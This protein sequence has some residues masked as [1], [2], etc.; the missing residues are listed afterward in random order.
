MDEVD[1]L[2]SDAQQILRH[3]MEKDA[4]NARFFLI[5]NDNNAIIPALQSR[6]ARFRFSPLSDN[7]IVMRLQ[8][9]CEAE[10]IKYHKSSEVLQ[11]I[12][13]LSCGDMRTAYSITESLCNTNQKEEQKDDVFLTSE[14]V[15]NLT[16][17]PSPEEV[18]LIF[19]ILLNEPL[20]V[21]FLQLSQILEQKQYAL[22]DIVTQLHETIVFKARFPP[23][24]FGFLM[25]EFGKL[26]LQIH[27]STNHKLQLGCLIGIFAKASETISKKES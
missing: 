7:Q 13:H 19:D 4:K 20:S 17:K 11:T 23:D 10:S 18:S 16:G 14:A 6:C 24:V 9:L 22:L 15:Y 12:A 3:I 1:Y 26:E 5:C 21:A 8:L 2:S 25:I 27:K